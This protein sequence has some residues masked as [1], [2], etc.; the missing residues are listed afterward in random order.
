[1]INQKYIPEGW[2]SNV[3][4]VDVNSVKRVFEEGKVLQGYVNECDSNY[5]LHIKLGN[6]I[7][8]ILPR[9]EL[10]IINTDEYGFCNPSICK[11][12]VNN[13]VQFKVKEVYNNNVIL[14]RK[15]VQREALEWVK[16]DLKPGTVVSGIVKNIRK[17]G[18]FVEIGGGV[19][20]LIH[21]EDISVSRIKSPEERFEIGQKINVMVKSIDKENNKIILSYKELLGNWEDNIKDYEEKTVV[22]G[23][24]K[25]PDKF[26][27]GIF[28]ELKPNLVGLAEYKDGLKYGQKVNVYIKKII[29]DKKKVKLLIV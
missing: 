28:I 21:I 17:F 5:N 25:E 11:N 15:S 1:M 24:V 29:K 10:E 4:E 3:D 2:N 22:E 26:K 23:T 19:V 9:N 20:G 14:S 18:A 6:G 8:G 13:F 7:T 12:K 27:N 16:N